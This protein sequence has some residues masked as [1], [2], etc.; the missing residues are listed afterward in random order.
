MPTHY[1]GFPLPEATET[2]LR[3]LL[4][5]VKKAEKKTLYAMDLFNVIVALSDIGLEY[6]FL[7][8]LRRAKIGKISYALI[9]KAINVGKGGI[10]FAGKSIV[11]GLDNEQLMIVVDLLDS[12][13]TVRPEKTTPPTTEDP[14]A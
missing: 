5:K 2:K 7:E 1:L 14:K 6:Y 8:P 10:V 4:D 3:E 9:S 12:S 11:K 13:L